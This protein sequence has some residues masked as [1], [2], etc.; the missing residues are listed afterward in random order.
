MD[1]FKDF[2][3]E[4]QEELKKQRAIS[5][6]KEFLIKPI[7]EGSIQKKRKY[8]PMKRRGE[9]TVT[10]KYK[11]KNV[12]IITANREFDFMKFYGIVKRWASVQYNLTID[13]IEM[14]MYF[15]SEPLFTKKE[16]DIYNTAMLHKNKSIKRFVDMGIVDSLPGNSS[17][18]VAGN[19][20]YKLSVQANRRVASIYKK[21]TLQDSISEIPA[22]NKF[23]RDCETSYKDK[24]IA[25][26]MIEY[27]NRRAEI[28]NGGNGVYLEDEIKR[29]GD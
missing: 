7:S 1:S 24:R 15:Y 19:R 3:L 21:L 14:M 8:R 5:Q 16:F 27:N 9:R 12:K 17:I 13:E 25:K 20:L 28:I 29:E 4:N 18:K 2:L 11:K 6:V 22:N 10:K 26:L 23:F